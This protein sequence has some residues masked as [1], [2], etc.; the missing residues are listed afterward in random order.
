MSDRRFQHDAL[1]GVEEGVRL[2]SNLIDVT[3]LYEDVASGLTLYKFRPAD[4]A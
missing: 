3:L 2:L 1:V 4:N